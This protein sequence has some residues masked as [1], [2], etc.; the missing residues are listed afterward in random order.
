M[1][2]LGIK[3]RAASE[4]GRA[5]DEEDREREAMK[6][7]RLV[8]NVNKVI[9]TAAPTESTESTESSATRTQRNEI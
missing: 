6:E 1:E 8:S 4:R 3:S 5:R 9:D 2:T 7:A